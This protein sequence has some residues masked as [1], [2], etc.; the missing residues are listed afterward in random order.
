M[1]VTSLTSTV[2]PS[3]SFD[4]EGG[5]L[6]V[7]RIEGGLAAQSVGIDGEAHV[8]QAAGRGGKVGDPYA[9]MDVVDHAGHVF[10]SIVA[11]VLEDGEIVVAVGQVV[12]DAPLAGD[13]QP[14]KLVCVPRRKCSW[15]LSRVVF[16]VLRHGLEAC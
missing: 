7:V 8:A 2:M 5:L 15:S 6:Q 4:F 14:P 13:A 3:G 12:A 16:P 11:L 10:R 1:V 9:D